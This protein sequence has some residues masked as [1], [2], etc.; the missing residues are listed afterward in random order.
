MLGYV[1]KRQAGHV[2]GLKADRGDMDL[3]YEILLKMGY[4]LT[5]NLSAYEVG[6]LM[7]YKISDGEMLICLQ[8]GITAEYIE[9]LADLKPKKIVIAESAFVDNST[10]SNAYYLLGNRGIELKVV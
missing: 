1:Y 3:V 10:M 5:V 4:F 7:V 2:E 9:I 8:S 6:G